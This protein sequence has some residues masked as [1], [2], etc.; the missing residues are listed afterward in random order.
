MSNYLKRLQSD[1][2]F[3]K[4]EQQ[5]PAALDTSAL[6]DALGELIRQAAAAG[7]EEAVRKQ[8]PHNPAVAEHRR[9]FTSEPLRDTFPPAPPRAKT[10]PVVTLSRGADGR[11]R[12][13]SVG[14]L[15]FTVQRDA[16]GR[17]VGMTPQE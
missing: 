6:N 17:A 8:P 5:P 1:P 15:V 4:K 7:A 3:Q 9:P 13:A 11:I 10:M 14:D 16:A 12:S 2:K